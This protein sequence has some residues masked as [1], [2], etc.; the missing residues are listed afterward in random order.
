MPLLLLIGE[1]GMTVGIP[2]LLLVVVDADATGILGG[3]GM[4]TGTGDALSSSLSVAIADNE[5]FA[6]F[7]GSGVTAA[8]RRRCWRAVICEAV[9]VCSERK[10]D[11][12]VFLIYFCEVLIRCLD[13][14]CYCD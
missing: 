6:R 9:S 5:L 12:F 11:F 1:A 4:R 8:V 13:S 3:V 14:F 2:I 10:T 7:C